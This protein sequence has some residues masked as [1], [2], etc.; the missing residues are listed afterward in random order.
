LD[1][2]CPECGAPADPGAR[3]CSGCGYPFLEAVARAKLPRPV[4]P[5]LAILTL[6]GVGAALALTLMGGQPAPMA[7]ELGSFSDV[8]SER[9]LS[10]RAAERRLEARFGADERALEA[11][12]SQREPRPVYSLRRCVIG[13]PTGARRMLVVFTDV[14]GRELLRGRRWLSLP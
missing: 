7:N 9:P 2:I 14:E 8:L 10:A 4:V 5:L 12:C 13:Q 3:S 6:A 1:T 11:H